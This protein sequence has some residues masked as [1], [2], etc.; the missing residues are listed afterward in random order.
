VRQ[1]V[2]A[3]IEARNISSS[4]GQADRVAECLGMIAVAGEL[5]IEF[6]IVP[7]QAGA[8]SDAAAWALFE[9]LKSVGSRPFEEQQAI[10]QVRVTI[11]RYGESRFDDMTAILDD[12][13]DL[14]PA[15]RLVTTKDGTTR[16]YQDRRVSDRLG[17]RRGDGPHRRWFVFPQTWVD[18]ICA[19]IDPIRTAALLADRGMLERGNEKDGRLQRQ[20]KI[21]G[22]K[23]R[24]YVLT[25]AILDCEDLGPL[26]APHMR[27]P[28]HKKHR[29]PRVPGLY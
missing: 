13:E 1:R 27:T 6:G 25:L 17:Y 10:A 11:A 16:S 28:Y 29:V 24:F 26:C 14:E 8:A 20:V 22:K 9:W 3:W 2:N 12:P 19:G 15:V 21:Q 18:V 4:H 23:H 5:A 7:W